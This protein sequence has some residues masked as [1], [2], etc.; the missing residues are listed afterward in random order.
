MSLQRMFTTEHL[1]NLLPEPSVVRNVGGSLEV[2]AN[3]GL[4][5]TVALAEGAED[6]AGAVDLP[7]A[8][9]ARLKFSSKA[10]VVGRLNFGVWTPKVVTA[11][12][13]S[14]R[15]EWLFNREDAPLR[16]SQVMFQTVLVPAGTDELKFRCR[17]YALIRS[18]GFIPIPTRFETN[19]LEVST[20][21]IAEF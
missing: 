5:G 13:C 7:V 18:V 2:G 4:N 6:G 19:W 8:G 10:D 15:C 14:S 12:M 9:G 11:G 21:P 17:T 3:V 16:N 20:A 1:I